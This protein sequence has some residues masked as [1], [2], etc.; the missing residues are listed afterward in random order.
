MGKHV[1]GF[2]VSINYWICYLY[3]KSEIELTAIDFSS[4]MLGM[5][6][7]KYGKIKL[8]KLNFKEYGCTEHIF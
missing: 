2:I 5:A 1:Y 3:Y 4:G 7:H 6:Q 8:K